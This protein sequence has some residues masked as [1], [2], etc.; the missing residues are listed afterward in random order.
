MSGS[1]SASN[2]PFAEAIDFLR[3]RLGRLL[4]ST[5]W[6]DTYGRLNAHGFAV[7][8]AWRDALLRDIGQAVLAHMEAGKP[9]RDFL[10]VFEEIAARHQWDYRGSA[11]WRART[12]IES[13]LRSA[14][15]AGRWK[16]AQ[17]FKATRPYLRY[18][19]VQDNR[20]RPL[21]ARWHGTI[22]PVDHPWWMTHFPP[23]GWGCRCTTIGL[24]ER[25]LARYG[26]KVTDPAPDVGLIPQRIRGVG[27]DVVAPVPAGIDPGW[28]HNP[29]LSLE[30]PL[31]PQLAEDL[32]A[33]RF[34][35]AIA[36]QAVQREVSGLRAPEVDPSL[37]PAM[38]EARPLDQTALLP[39]DTSEQAAMEAFLE[40]FGATPDGE[41]VLYRDVAGGVL[42]IG[43]R[44]FEAQ[45]GQL[46]VSKAGRLPYLRLLADTLRDPDEV[47]VTV[48]IHGADRVLPDG[49][50]QRARVVVR[51]RYITRYEGQDGTIAGVSAFE[52]DGTTWQGRTIFP[53]GVV[54]SDQE[55]Q[56]YLDGR[57]RYGVRLYRRE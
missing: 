4:P 15:A 20:T 1:V 47:W 37:L 13:N 8:G 14:Y 2:V 21:H 55:L 31:V 49:T 33:G 46:K 30:Q 22:L 6:T 44:L 27:T 34:V 7:A 9:Y 26:W 43:R 54:P 53:A 36:R 12:I 52:W 19:A 48:E 10:P 35:G 45:S 50:M 24:S 51:R 38:P 17:R 3:G 16:M 40:P 18:V 39:A 42:G 11:A 32:Q 29:G 28:D 23:N 25:Q 57:A 5:T 41:P 56:D